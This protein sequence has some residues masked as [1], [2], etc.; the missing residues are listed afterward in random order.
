MASLSTEASA[1]LEEIIKPMMAAQPATLGYPNETSQSSYYPGKER[2]TMEE[3]EAL[4]KIMEAKKIAPENTRL[5]KETNSD[6]SVKK[7]KI[8]QASAEQD[9][10]LQIL[11]DFEIGDQR[12]A[13]VLLCRGDHNEEMAKICI[14]LTEAC[15]HAATREQKTAL[16]QLTQSFRTGDYEAFRSAHKT[17]VN[18]KAPRVE[19]CMGF[20]FGYRDPYGARAEWQAAAGIAHSEET[21]KMSQLVERSPEFI[22]TLPWAVPDEN[23][24][25]G[26]FEPS[27][28][29]VPDFAIIHGKYITSQLVMERE[30]S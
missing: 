16:S 10:E 24:G 3:I 9:P 22:R 29:D 5:L 8:L 1:K 20:L 4:T 17:W 19:H 11:G 28:L 12:S 25:K 2:I 7:F 27:E 30:P 15:K 14:E 21:S 13:R 6:A 18:D 26:P 23:D